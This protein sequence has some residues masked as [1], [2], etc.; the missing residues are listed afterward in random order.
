MP[1]YKENFVFPN[2]AGAT[3]AMEMRTAN[4]GEFI[5]HSLDRIAGHLEQLAAKCRLWKREHSAD[6][7]EIDCD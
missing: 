7:P 5:A 6:R 4:A 1:A 2:A 3:I